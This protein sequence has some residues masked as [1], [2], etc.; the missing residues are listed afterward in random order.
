MES[1]EWDEHKALENLQ[2]H[3][4][5]FVN[6]QEAFYD[7][8]RVIFRDKKHSTTEE[9]FFCLG[10]VNERVMTV[11]F[12]IRQDK[13]RIIGAAYWRKGDKIYEQENR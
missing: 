1:F 5:S 6:A 4:V 10:I 8:K 11:R 13:I 3:Q 2:K 9:R 7:K 12:T